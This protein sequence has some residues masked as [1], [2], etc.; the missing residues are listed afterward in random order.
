M[1]QLAS[2]VEQRDLAVE[3]EHHGGPALEPLEF[4]VRND[5]V[6]F[7]VFFYVSFA[8]VVWELENGN[9]DRNSRTNM[10]Y[11]TIIRIPIEKYLN[12]ARFLV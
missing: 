12:A 4:K 7:V 9:L 2:N 1:H 8:V 6:H 5:P 11:N 3:G 10:V